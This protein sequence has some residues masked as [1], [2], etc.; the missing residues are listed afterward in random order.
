MYHEFA[1]VSAGKTLQLIK[2]NFWWPYMSTDVDQWCNSCLVCAAVNQGRP[3]RMN[4]R[5][6]D[7]PKGPREFLQVDFI[8]LLPSARG[9][10]RYCLV[11]I[12]RFSK[13]VEAIPTR[14][15]TATTVARVLVNQIIPLWGAPMQIE[16]DQG[17]HFTGQVTKSVCK[18]LN[19][20]QKFHVPYRPQSSGMVECVNRMIKE[21]IAK[22]M[23]Q[24]QNQWTEALP[25]V[26]TILRATP[27]RATGVSPYEL[28][29]GRVMRLPIHPEIS[30][31]DLGPLV[32]AK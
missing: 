17:T 4:L 32:L 6:P 13:W 8:G 10:Y 26:L 24:H 9:W 1:H 16:S 3:G 28:M 15:N 31:A 11:I 22:Q 2:I 25:T 23:T 30:P 18:M 7:P 27:S 14:S 29:T 19:I 21:G 20:V 12:D 5:R